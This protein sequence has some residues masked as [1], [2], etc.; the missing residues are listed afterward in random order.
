MAQAPDQSAVRDLPSLHELHRRHPGFHTNV[1]KAYADAARVCFSRHHKSPQ[2]LLVDDDGARS[3]W[4]V[5][6]ENPTLAVQRSHA[7]TDDATRDGAYAVALSALEATRGLLALQRAERRSGADYLVVPP[8]SDLLEDA[9]RFEVSGTDLSEPDVRS[10]MRE[11]RQQ[12]MASR[13]DLPGLAC[14]VGFKIKQVLIQAV[15]AEG[16]SKKPRKAK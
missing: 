13:R 14:V 8:G 12:L 4:R 5:V 15:R 1:C 10:R 6:W 16:S 7:N 9:I 11:K 2:V 3:D